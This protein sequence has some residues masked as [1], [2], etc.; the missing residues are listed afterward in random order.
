MSPPP[1]APSRAEPPQT[2]RLLLRALAPADL[3]GLCAIFSDP[4]AMRHYPSTR[5]REQTRG[6]LD[7]N[8]EMYGALG[9]GMWAAVLRETGRFVGTVGLVAQE[10]EGASE[11]ELGYLL[12][13]EFWGRGLATEAALAC[14]DFGFHVLGKARLVSLIDP[15]NAPS[16]RV[17]DRVGM[18]FE[19]EIA[20]W[21]K[22]VCLYARD[23]AA[24]RAR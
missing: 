15:A 4:R 21:D 1:R 24:E 18:R 3:D 7:W 16:R 6:W 17:A 12:V 11:T 10:V 8:L 5:T 2:E 13:R 23:R 20:K 14:R 19:R 22:R 9:Y